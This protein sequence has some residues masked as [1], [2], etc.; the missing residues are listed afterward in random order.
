MTDTN[1]LFSTEQALQVL[2]ERWGHRHF[3]KYQKQALDFISEGDDVLAVLPTGEGKSVLFQLPALFADG[4][5]I[6]ISPLIALMKDQVDAAQARGIPAACINSNMDEEEQFEALEGFQCGTF[7]LLYIAPE[8]INSRGFINAIQ[9]C[10]VSLVAVD[11]AHCCSQWG[12]DFRPDYMHIHRLISSVSTDEYRPQVIMCTATATKLVVEDIVLALGL[13]HDGVTRVIADPIRPNLRYKVVDGGIDG[14]GNLWGQL[15]TVL[16]NLDTRA[17]KHIVYA[18]TRKGAEKVAEICDEEQGRRGI[19]TVYHAGMKAENR[20]SVQ[21]DFS[22]PN[23]SARIVCATTAFGMGVDVPNIR[24]V[25]CFGYPGSV[26]DYTQQIGRAGR[27]GL[28]SD[29]ILIGDSGSAEWQ[30]QLIENAN[31][32]WTHYGVLWEWLH[33]NTQPGSSIR[34]SRNDI[35]QAIARGRVANLSPEQVGVALKRMHSAGIIESRSIQTSIPVTTNVPKLRACIDDPGKA[36]PSIVHVWRTFLENCVEPALADP[37]NRNVGNTLVVWINKTALQ[38]EAGV[39]QWYVGRALD[40]LQTRERGAVLDIGPAQSGVIVKILKWRADLA[41][42]MPVA[43]IEEK[44]RRDFS[45]F[46]RLLNYSRL[47]NEDER[48]SML[49]DYFLRT[50]AEES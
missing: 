27:D 33:N 36:K 40:A 29:T 43:K 46:Q 31:P 6:V 28:Q 12:H 7:K 2:R 20:T 13:T 44:R 17:G 1:I 23:G 48:K 30:M 22:D 9:Q 24:S 42:E 14:H 3:R 47:R 38:N 25:V 21:E 34:T 50:D 26:E 5:T 4:G 35:S 49:R 8:R 32:P 15:R 18:G 11:E 19:A 37:E 39:S 10:D 45:R 16:R 41:G